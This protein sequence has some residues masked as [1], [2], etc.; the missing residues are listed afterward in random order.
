MKN[1]ADE[2]KK[3]TDYMYPFAILF[4]IHPISSAT[5][6]KID[7]TKCEIAILSIFLSF[8]VPHNSKTTVYGVCEYFIYQMI[9]LLL[10]IFLSAI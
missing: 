2:C 6:L 7:K 4:Q 10:E 5:F 1:K 3:C 9:A 8:F